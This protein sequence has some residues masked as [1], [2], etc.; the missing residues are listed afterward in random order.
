MT[1]KKICFQ[2][3]W[4]IGISAGFFLILMSVSGAALSFQEEILDA[5]NPG[6]ISGAKGEGAVLTPVQLLQA[7]QTQLVT[8][9]RNIERLELYA[10]SDRNPSI[11]FAALPGQSH[12]ERAWVHA[13]TGQL[14]TM[15][16]GSRFF[17]WMERLHIWLLLP[18]RIGQPLTG[19]FSACLLV[20]CLSGLYLRWPRHHV[21]SLK[22]WLH[23]RLAHR[24]RPLLW[25]LHA[26]LGTWALLVYLVLAVT[27]MYWGLTPL[28]SL[29][30]GWAG[31]APRTAT[32]AVAVASIEP[33][34]N[35]DKTPIPQ[36]LH[37]PWSQFERLA[38]QAGGW[39]FVQI[40]LPRKAGQDYQFN[41]LG[42]DAPHTMAR[43][44]TRI[45]SDG[46]IKRDEAYANLNTARQG[47]TSIYPLHVGSYFGL[48]GRIVMMLASL[49]L[50]L[51]VI[52]GWML[53]LDRRRKASS[54][55]NSGL[56]SV[57]KLIPGQVQQTV[58]VIYASQSGYA[59]SLA[60][61]TT[62]RIRRSGHAVEL[63]SAAKI[64]PLSLNRFATTLWVVSTFGD[65][66]APDDARKLLCILQ[67]TKLPCPSNYAVFAL[68]DRQY[69]HFCS[70]GLKVHDTLNQIGSIALFDAVLQDGESASGWD[71]WCSMLSQHG[72]VNETLPSREP[73]ERAFSEYQLIDRVYCNPQS[74]GAPLYR[75]ELQ[76][77][78]R[79]S[80][81]WQAG[82]IAEI[83]IPTQAK[84]RR[85][86][87]LH[88][89]E[90]ERPRRYSVASL[91]EDGYIQL[92]VRQ[93]Q[94]GG[95]LGLMS[96][97][98]TQGM[99]LNGRIQLRLLAN[100]K[101]SNIDTLQNRAIFI[102]SGSGYAGLRALL[103]DRIRC[104]QHQNWLIF[105]ERD[106]QADGWAEVEVSCWK[107]SGQLLHA[108]FAYSRD[109]ENPCYVQQLLEKNADR[110][111]DWVTQGAVIYVCGSYQGMGNDVEQMLKALL[112]DDVFHELQT[113][114][115]YR[116]D[117][118]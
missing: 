70:F 61:T 41:W 3:H 83:L 99:Q 49:L 63:I 109:V 81:H 88:T 13:Y 40:R 4:C 73:H 9:P 108:D 2:L 60:E 91:A 117:V 115:R 53:Y 32:V 66:D 24:G 5:L 95:H 65:G 85:V 111:R 107:D 22:N 105:G 20:L 84:K 93:V 17:D 23:L 106:R 69:T 59:R 1:F 75:L 92:W 80:S 58:A 28:R 37:R 116:R 21:W 47:L 44:R 97:W 50:P 72:L 16:I 78:H 82:T 18:T 71:R 114:G 55:I 6:S 74:P 25:N 113:S 43:N 96:G 8:T 27:G 26:V 29:V 90:I 100:P 87:V 30:D 68:G 56:Q 54:F 101:F 52:T 112:K 118:Y 39:Q 33:L 34:T 67:K 102:G 38:R 45:D 86:N 77:V 42:T 103:L 76:A 12:G 104:N 89:N 11:T 110:L 15:L 51:F 35:P 64:D 46:Q 19:I 14:Q 48:T 31:I 57:E 10:F 62:Q 7:L 79:T 94:H 98:L 36:S